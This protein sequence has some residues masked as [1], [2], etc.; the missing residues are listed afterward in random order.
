MAGTETTEAGRRGA[1]RAVA[2]AVVGLALGAAALGA[3]SSERAKA[4]AEQ[5]G[6]QVCLVRQSKY[7]V[8]LSGSGLQD[9]SSFTAA[10]E[11]AGVP[12]PSSAET[13]PMEVSPGGIAGGLTLGVTSLTGQGLGDDSRVVFTGIAA[14]GTPVTVTVEVPG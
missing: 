11:G 12:D 1:P 2:A 5:S 9:G 6:V 8:E 10:L 13:R 7:G 4:C 14:D 3:C